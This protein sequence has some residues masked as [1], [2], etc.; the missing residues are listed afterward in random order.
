MPAAA[1]ILYDNGPVN[2]NVNA[3]N[4]GSGFAV[5]DSFYLPQA[6]VVG[7]ISFWAWLFP[8]DILNS[9]EMSITSAENG[10]TVYY[11]Q[12]LSA[13]QGFCVLNQQGSSVCLENLTIG[14]SGLDLNAGTY[15]LNLFNASA[16]NGDPVY[17]DENSGVG[18]MSQ[19]CPSLA[20][21]NIVGTIPSE[22]FQVLGG[23]T[24]SSGGTTPE[25]ASILLF[26]SGIASAGLLRRRLLP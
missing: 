3:W 19:G 1:Q 26:A 20:S 17:W 18:C 9:A 25:P 14:G 21:Q 5:S 22:S 6:N 24:T 11:N 23:D 4:I 16:T 15:W 8:G 7:G 13:A 10:G 12:V 2:G